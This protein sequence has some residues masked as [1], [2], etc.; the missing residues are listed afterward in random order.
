M[1]ADQ[2]L[3]TEQVA[4]TLGLHENAGR[5]LLLRTIG[6]LLLIAFLVAA[7]L[8]LR[9]RNQT[10]ADVRYEA[11]PVTRGNLV[12]TVSATG[13]LAPV[14]EVEVGS[15]VS[16]TMKT[17]EVDYNDRVKVGQVL[18][19]IDTSK[20][21]AQMQQSESALQSARAKVLEAEATLTESEAQLK[22]LRQAR[23]LSGGKV[24]S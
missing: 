24:P 13:T 18:A 2:A 10:E 5:R 20:L 1:N 15:E 4:E 22:R 19:R 17:V 23:E 9:G 14:N 16:G 21:A 6:F 12:E 8:I 7:L 3:Q 11:Q